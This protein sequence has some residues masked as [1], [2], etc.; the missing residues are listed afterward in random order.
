MKKKKE[1]KSCCLS[2]ML[3]FVTKVAPYHN[4]AVCHRGCDL[5]Q[6]CGLSPKLRFISETFVTKRKSCLIP[7]CTGTAGAE[8]E[9]SHR[10]E[11]KAVKDF[12]F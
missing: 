2:Q 10:W 3:H 7:L 6:C 4:V 5:S 1:K 12:L 11:S 8:V 9:F